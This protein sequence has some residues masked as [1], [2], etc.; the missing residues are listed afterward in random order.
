MSKSKKG[1][2]AKK[3]ARSRGIEGE[4]SAEALDRATGGLGITIF[5]GIKPGLG[6]IDDDD[7]PLGPTGPTG[8][9]PP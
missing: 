1:A 9:L 2:S 4:L 3:A 6:I 7:P 8:P 5:G